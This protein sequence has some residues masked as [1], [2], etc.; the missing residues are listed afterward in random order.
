MT[1]PKKYMKLPTIVEAIQYTGE[2]LEACKKFC[3]N[4]DSANTGTSVYIHTLEGTMECSLFDFIV[5]GIHGEFYPCKEEI[6]LK[7]HKEAK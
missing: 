6:F 2:N 5:K 3:P 4:L 7:L 1:E